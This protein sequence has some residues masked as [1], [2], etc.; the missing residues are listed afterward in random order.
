MK[1]S[2]PES[3]SKLYPFGKRSLA[4]ALQD[5]ITMAMASNQ[6][7]KAFDLCSIK[8]S[9]EWNKFPVR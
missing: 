3:A 2:P 7:H 9:L 8:A 4:Q 5:R 1:I 6:M